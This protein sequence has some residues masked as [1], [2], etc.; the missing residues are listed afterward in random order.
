VHRQ[1]QH[2]KMPSMTVMDPILLATQCHQWIHIHRL[3]M[4]VS[5]MDDISETTK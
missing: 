3:C 2:M 1:Q 4:V 5:E